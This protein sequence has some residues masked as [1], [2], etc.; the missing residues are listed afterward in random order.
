[1]YSK[2]EELL[3]KS[4]KTTYRVAKDIGIS[5]VTFTDWKKGRSQPKVDKLQK[6]AKYFDVPIGYFIEE[7]K[8]NNE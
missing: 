4:N 6:I 3:Q 1:M 8:E 2:F 5:S 7:R